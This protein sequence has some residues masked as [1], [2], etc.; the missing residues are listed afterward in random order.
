MRQTG[1]T[2]MMVQDACEK[3][4]QTH[5]RVY[6]VIHTLKF[7]GYIEQLINKIDP[8]LKGK[9]IIVSARRNNIFAHVEG[10]DRDRIFVDHFVFESQR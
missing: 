8:K 3:A 4:K 2:T 6:I 1:R 7:K 9:I 5:K 10:V